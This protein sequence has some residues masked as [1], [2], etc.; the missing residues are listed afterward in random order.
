MGFLTKSQRCGA[1]LSAAAL[2]ILCAAWIGPT[3]AVEAQPDRVLLVIVSA[4]TGGD[5]IGLSTLRQAFGGYTTTHNG[6][7]LIPFNQAV[8]TPSRT[9]F[10]NR[11]LGLSADEVG[12]YWIDRKIRQG[13][14]P[15]RKLPSAETV[16]RVVASLP[17]AISYIEMSPSALPSALRALRIDG[18]R[19]TEPGYVFR[20]R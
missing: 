13:T 6:R 9:L 19:P 3:P 8:G 1:W 18:V 20:A 5:D 14:D 15:P 4:V 2:G 11:V 16:I 12:A 17:G 7:R 10:D